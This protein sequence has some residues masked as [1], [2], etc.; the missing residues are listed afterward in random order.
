MW[1]GI[2]RVTSLRRGKTKVRELLA[3]REATWVKNEE[4]EGQ[5]GPV[6]EFLLETEV[7]A[8][9]A[10]PREWRAEEDEQEERKERLEQERRRR[11]EELERDEEREDRR[12][13]GQ[14]NRWVEEVL[15]E[16]KATGH[17]EEWEFLRNR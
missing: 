7:G 14:R 8:W 5:W 17:W 12:M 1:S 16:W 13:E 9:R 6:V 3:K 2:E 10:V 4:G 15:E 11:E